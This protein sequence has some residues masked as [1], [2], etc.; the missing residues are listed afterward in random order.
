MDIVI[1]ADGTVRAP[2]A[3]NL[4]LAA[5]PRGSEG[6]PRP[7][8]AT[9]SAVAVGCLSFS[10]ARP[11]C[12]SAHTSYPVRHRIVRQA[13]PITSPFLVLFP[14]KAARPFRPWLSDMRQLGRPPVGS[15]RALAVARVGVVGPKR[16]T[17]PPNRSLRDRSDDRSVEGR[18]LAN[19]DH[20]SPRRADRAPGRCR[21]GGACLA[22]RTPPAAYV[23]D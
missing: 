2:Y 7:G 3:E 14:P 6:N 21:A 13:P 5:H 23:I 19:R 12:G 20:E 1:T 17:R 9:A 11:I 22:V 16:A 8:S 18:G 10:S 4:E 15:F